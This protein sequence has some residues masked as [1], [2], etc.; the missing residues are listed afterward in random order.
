MKAKR[1]HCTKKKRLQGGTRRGGNRFKN[2]PPSNEYDVNQR[3]SLF[4]VW[5]RIDA[6]DAARA[7]L[8]REKKE[9]KFA[10]KR[11]A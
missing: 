4:V 6:S 5:M 1:F 2:S 10:G 3:V 7:A 8:F 11:I 9:R